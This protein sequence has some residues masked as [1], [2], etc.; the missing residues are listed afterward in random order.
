VNNYYR[1]STR[2]TTAKNILRREVGHLRPLPHRLPG[3]AF[4]VR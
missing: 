3:R 2:Q 1:G 4:K